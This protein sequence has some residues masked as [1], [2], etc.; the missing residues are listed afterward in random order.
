[1]RIA[2]VAKNPITKCEAGAADP[3]EKSLGV[4]FNVRRASEDNRS[5][6]TE[7]LEPRLGLTVPAVDDKLIN[8]SCIDPVFRQSRHNS[9]EIVD[10]LIARIVIPLLLLS[11]EDEP[12][13][14][15][16]GDSPV[17]G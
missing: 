9:I 14:L 2:S 4:T 16:N 13:I 3:I 1:M 6:P 15:D 7:D 8:I 11:T 17:M 10:F 12:S 5:L